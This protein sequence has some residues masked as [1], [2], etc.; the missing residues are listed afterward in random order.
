MATYWIAVKR[1]A[2]DLVPHDW[3]ERLKSIPGVRVPE[4]ARVP[5]VRIEAE[6]EAI[7]VVKLLLGEFCHVERESFR[8]VEPPAVF[9]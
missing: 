6:P 7:A 2:R 8:T 1:E 5:R 4:G 3:I 9:P